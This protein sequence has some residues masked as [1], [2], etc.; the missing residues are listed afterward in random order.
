MAL[1]LTPWASPHPFPGHS[2]ADLARQRRQEPADP[3][4][5]LTPWASLLQGI[6][7]I[8]WALGLYWTWDR[9]AVRP[10]RG[11]HTPPRF[12]PHPIVPT[13]P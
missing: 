11:E 10:V 12:R 1:G 3:S 13:T 2:L 7:V 6:R 5:G 4:T 8:R 9:W